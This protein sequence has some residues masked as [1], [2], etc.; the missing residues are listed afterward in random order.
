MTAA[1]PSVAVQ[2]WLDEFGAALSRSD[3]DAAAALFGDDGYWRDLVVVHLEHQ[4]RRRRASRS[5]R[6]SQ[7]RLPGAQ[8]ANWQLRARPARPAA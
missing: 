7:R 3:F 2:A 1:S 5:A 4:D 6:C 8:P